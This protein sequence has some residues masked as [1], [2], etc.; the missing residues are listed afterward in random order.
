MQFNGIYLAFVNN[1]SK[2][3][4][5]NIYLSVHCLFQT[6]YHTNILTF[7]YYFHMSVFLTLHLHSR[8]HLSRGAILIYMIHE[9]M[10]Y[11]GNNSPF[12]AL[13]GVRVPWF[14]RGALESHRHL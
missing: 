6:H 9:S 14:V 4:K 13:G 10:K 2:S 1:I 11:N 12:L 3:T 7:Q 5:M 8:R